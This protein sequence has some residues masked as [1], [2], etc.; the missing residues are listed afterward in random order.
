M[1]TDTL[2]IGDT[3]YSRGHV[4]VFKGLKTDKADELSENQNITIKANLE[5]GTD[6]PGELKT[7]E[8]T[9]VISG[10]AQESIPA[11]IRE[12]KMMV[13]MYQLI[14]LGEQR[15]KVVFNVWEIPT[16]GE[17]VVMQ[18]IIF[19]GINWVWLGSIMMMLGLL[20]GLLKKK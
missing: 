7:I 15:A 9:L 5:V 18:A 2:E 14:P 3:L 4:I 1:T 6:V 20:M 16:E 12:W 13:Q 19:P 8:P 17:Y 11:E 10:T